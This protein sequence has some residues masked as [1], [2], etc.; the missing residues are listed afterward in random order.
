MS[1]AAQRY[2]QALFQLAQANGQLSALAQPLAHLQA[3][4][5]QLAGSLAIPRLTPPQRRQLALSLAQAVQ[6][7]PLLAN[8]LRLMADNRRLELL[9][10][11]LAHLQSLMDAANGTARLQIETA[12][13]LSPQQRAQLE[14]VLAPLAG[15]SKIELVETM[16]PRLMAGVRAFVNGQVWDASLRGRLARLQA[17]LSQAIKIT[18]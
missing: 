14:Q 15:A 12:H 18:H 13:P 16:Q 3:V 10:D 2:A 1:T 11:M 4:V 7:P 9:P 6:A 17:S 5:P 8:T